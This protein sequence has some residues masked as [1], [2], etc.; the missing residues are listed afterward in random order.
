MFLSALDYALGPSYEVALV[1]SPEDE[2][3]ANMLRA[4]RSRFLPNK[5][6]IVVS[7]DDIRKLAQ[8]TRNLSQ[9]NGEATAYVCAD[10]SCE[11]P[12]N[13]LHRMIDILEG[14]R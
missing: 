8:F 11:I 7:G 1:G 4:V 5:A 14:N 6:V 2:G 3:I 9:L 12:T 10:Y 13:D